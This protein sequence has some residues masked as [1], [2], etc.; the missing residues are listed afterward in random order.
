MG[1]Q[2]RRARRA[3]R[4]VRH[5]DGWLFTFLPDV[6]A[7]KDDPALDDRVWEAV[8]KIGEAHQAGDD[9]TVSRLARFL[10]ARK[11]EVS[12]DLDGTLRVQFPWV[13]DEQPEQP[14]SCS[15][16]SPGYQVVH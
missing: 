16:F 14:K 5:F 3:A 10:T 2:T 11:I 12:T 1:K 4:Q 15:R 9:A 8:E 7:A 13:L 6:V